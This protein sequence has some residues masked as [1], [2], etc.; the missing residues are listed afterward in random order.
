[1]KT[2]HRVM[3]EVLTPEE[4]KLWCSKL[5]KKRLNNILLEIKGKFIKPTP[6]NILMLSFSWNKTPPDVEYWNSLHNY[7]G[8]LERKL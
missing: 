5:T 4:Y 1:M 3:Y 2:P 6:S 8:E 7:L